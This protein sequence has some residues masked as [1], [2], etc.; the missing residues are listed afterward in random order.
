MVNYWH[1]LAGYT[2]LYRSLLRFCHMRT[3]DA[4]ELLYTLNTANI[5]SHLYSHPDE[6]LR[7]STAYTF[8]SKLDAR[9]RPYRTEVQ[10]YKALCALKRS[11]D[12]E[13]TTA[14]QRE[15]VSRLRCLIGNIQYGFFKTYGMEIDDMRTV[16][17]LCVFSPRAERKRAGCMPVARLGVPALGV[18]ATVCHRVI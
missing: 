18:K 15:G 1:S 14:I 5:D 13:V 16:F 11:I 2:H 10:L 3:G 12:R 7:E 9:L 17:S 8:C 6:V 4:K